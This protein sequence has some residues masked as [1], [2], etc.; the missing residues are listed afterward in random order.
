MRKAYGEAD[1]KNG[2]DG[3]IW[4]RDPSVPNAVLYQAEPR[5]DKTY[6]ICHLPWIVN[7]KSKF[8]NVQL[9]TAAYFFQIDI[10]LNLQ[11]TFVILKH[12]ELKIKIS[13]D[14][15]KSRKIITYQWEI[16]YPILFP[17]IHNISNLQPGV[18]TEFRV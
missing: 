6:L 8:L 7:P 4:T 3:A 2:R 1:N 17:F 10:F 9:L 16:N 18:L 13:S 15:F 14:T 12:L 11:N 5:P